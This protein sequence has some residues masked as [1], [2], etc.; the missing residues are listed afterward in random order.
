MLKIAIDA[1][2]IL[3][4]QTGIVT[5]TVN[6]VKGL[7]AI[8]SENRY[9][10]YIDSFRDKEVGE[11]NLVDQPNFKNAVLPSKGAL[12]KQFFLP[13]NLALHKPDIFHSPTSTIPAVRPCPTVVTFCD[14]FHE[15]NPEWLPLKVKDRLSRLYKFAALKSD[16]II[17]ISHNTKNDLIKYYGVEPEKVSVIYPGKD[18]YFGRLGETEREEGRKELEKKYGIRGGFI[19]HV[20]AL[21]EWRNVPRLIEAFGILKL[22]DRIPHKLLL[23]GREVWGLKIKK[24]I[25]EAGL[26]GDV[27]NLDYVPIED[28][29]L[30]YNT[31]ELL[32]FPSLFE[33]FGIPVLEAQACGTPVVAS[34]KTALP[35]AVG[36]AGVLVDPYD[37]GVIADGVRKVLGD[38]ALRDDLIKKGFEHAKRFNW[39]KMARETLAV[40]QSG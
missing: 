14:L 32:V 13:L 19:L 8:D 35:E 38:G 5:Y 18:E 7:A 11:S 17:A 37:T 39:E 22:V 21:A 2:D 25:E 36:D 20:G 9:T 34:N 28:L 40:Y 27:I 24:I 26:T 4:K 3:R 33:G 15:A 31:A 23:V 16:K 30:L 12:W 29:R 10:I 1:R 6:L